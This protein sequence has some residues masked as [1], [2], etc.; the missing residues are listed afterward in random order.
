MLSFGGALTRT[1][2][3]KMN[4]A[5]VVA[6][7]TLWFTDGPERGGAPT[8]EEKGSAFRT[9]RLSSRAMSLGSRESAGM[10]C[11]SVARLEILLGSGTL[12]E[13]LRSNV[14]VTTLAA[15]VSTL[16]CAL[17]ANAAALMVR[18]HSRERCK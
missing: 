10:L 3:G 4:P 9:R 17:R 12:W 14:L 6:P 16:I 1:N 15:A 18:R 7:I 2:K 8:S 11:C 13:C 5:L